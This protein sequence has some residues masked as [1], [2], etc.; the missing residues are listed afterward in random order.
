MLATLTVMQ[1]YFN[2]SKLNKNLFLNIKTTRGR[3]DISLLKFNKK[4]SFSD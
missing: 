1:I 3:G 4:K 2:T